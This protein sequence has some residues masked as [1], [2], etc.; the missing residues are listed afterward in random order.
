MIVGGTGTGTESLPC[1]GLAPDVQIK[2]LPDVIASEGT[3]GILSVFV[4]LG[5]SRAFCCSVKSR[6]VALTRGDEAGGCG[7]RGGSLGC[8]FRFDWWVL[9]GLRGTSVAGQCQALHV[10]ATLV[11]PIVLSAKNSNHFKPKCWWCVFFFGGGL[12]SPLDISPP[13]PFHS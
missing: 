10:T 4:S 13:P 3:L 6:R 9:A 12:P 5:L 1:S 11:G 8:W 7:G 2:P